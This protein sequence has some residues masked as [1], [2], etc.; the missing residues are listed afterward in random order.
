MCIRDRNTGAPV[1][2]R[3]LCVYP[4][5]PRYKGSGDPDAASSFVCTTP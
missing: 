1:L 3:P 4:A 5:Y 2:S